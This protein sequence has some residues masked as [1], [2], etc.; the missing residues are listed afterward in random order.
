LPLSRAAILGCLTLVAASPARCDE[1]PLVADRPGFGE[2]ASAVGTGHL[3]VEGG[4]TWTRLDGDTTVADAPQL[5]LRIGVARSLE[6]RVVAPDWSEGRSAGRRAAGWADTSV[7]VKGHLAMR[8]HDLSLRATAYLPS[9]DSGFS[10]ERLDPELALAWSH[11][12][13]GPWSLAGT[14]GERWLGPGRQALTS[15]SLSLG[16]SLGARVASFVEY[17]AAL[18]RRARPVHRLDHGYTWTPGPRTQLDVSLGIAL[19]LAAPDF[20]VAAGVCHRF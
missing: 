8:G 1:P 4:A 14:L 3:Q 13:S 6:L 11:P 16:R 12:I 2:S 7:G 18:G 17:G 20:F 9:G 10:S 19:S 5:L 15:P